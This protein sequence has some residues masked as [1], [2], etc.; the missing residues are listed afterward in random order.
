M[1][2]IRAFVGHSFTDDDK[3]VVNCFLEY[4]AQLSKSHSNFS[5]DHAQDAEPRIVAEKVMSLI[6][7]KN[8]F[9]GICTGKERVIDRIP[10]KIN[11]FNRYIV[12]VREGAVFWKTSDWIIQEIGLAI[13]LNLKVIL[14]IESGVRRPG[15]LQSDL[16]YIEF[17]RAAPEKSFGKILE[18]ISA[19]SPKKELGTSVMTAGVQS[20]P[21]DEK[22][23][24][25]TL[26]TDFSPKL[27]WT[28]HE[29][30]RTM[31]RMI[32]KNDEDKVQRINQ[33]YLATKHASQGDNKINWEAKIEV[34]RLIFERDGNFNNLRRF[35]EN[36]PDSSVVFECLATGYEYYNDYRAAA[37]AYEAAAGKAQNNIEEQFRLLKLAAVAHSHAGDATSAAKVIEQMKVQIKPTGGGEMQLLNALRGVA[38]VAKENETLI[39]TME[40]VVD[41]DPSDTETRFALA[42]KHSNVGNNDLAL[43]H[44]LKIPHGERTSMAWNNLG[45]AFDQCNLPSKSVQAYRQAAQENETLAM[46][47]LALKFI[48]AG[49][50]P[51]AQQQCDAALKIENYHQNIPRTMSHLKNQQDEENKKEEEILEETKPISDFYAA[52]GRA[53]SR[54][55]PKDIAKRWKE[56][57]CILAATLQGPVF[58]ATGSY[59]EQQYGG[60]FPSGSFLSSSSTKSVRYQIRYHGSVRGCAIEGSVTREREEERQ[61]VKSLLGS[62]ENEAKVLMILSNDGNE[63]RVMERKHEDRPTFYTLKCESS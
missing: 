59:E 62:H 4:F 58:E 56:K 17:D 5:W 27:E 49:F 41:L 28:E 13:G 53:V 21:D 31:E 14:L 42:Y 38:E 26:D 20:A 54:V 37:G 30:M 44:Y 19:L 35:A 51:E 18:M 52:F 6:E 61:T 43:F 40:R 11:F 46:S 16:E 39:A 57:K 36:H 45:V 3:A 8:V 7:N 34:F 9:I 25:E 2:E 50:L 29:Y 32:L 47:N 33:A 15:G 63:L 10:F 24:T 48:T 12:C 60:F 55:T 22:N 1:Q 23:M